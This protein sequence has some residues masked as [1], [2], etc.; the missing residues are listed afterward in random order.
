MEEGDAILRFMA[1]GTFWKG[2][3]DFIWWI[4]FGLNLYMPSKDYVVVSC[5]IP[6]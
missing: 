4:A 6:K 5:F 1:L 2:L 3:P